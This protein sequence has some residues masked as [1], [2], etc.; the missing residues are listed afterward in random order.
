MIAHGCDALHPFVDGE[1]APE[2]ADAY[3]DH[4]VSCGECQERLPVVMA[5]VGMLEAIAE[6]KVEA[7]RLAEVVPF[8][9]RRTRLAVL[10]TVGLVAAAGFA[11]WFGLRGVSRP[12]ESIAMGRT[13]PSV[14]R[15]AYPGAATY[16][17]YDPDRGAESVDRIPFTTLA[18]ME[19]R[20]DWHG[21][22]VAAAL[23]GDREQAA[24]Y[25]A[26]ATA[27]PDVVVDRAALALMGRDDAALAEALAALEQVLAAHPD[28][29]A[30]AWN[31]AHILAR[32]G[33]SRIAAE[34]FERIAQRGEPQ[35][36]AEAT[37]TAASLRTTTA[38]DA[39]GWQADWDA[40]RELI[41]NGTLPA[42]RRATA[43]PGI[44]RLMFYD[45]VRTAPSADRVRA[46]LPLARELDAA[47]GGGEVLAGLIRRV[48]AARFD[49][50]GPL[51]ARYRTFVVDDVYPDAAAAARYLDEL[52]AAGPDAADLLLGALYRFGVAAANLDEYRRL[53]AGDP[54]FVALAAHEQARAALARGDRADAASVLIAAIRDAR[55]A[56]VHYRTE[57]L[58]TELAELYIALDRL[59]DAAEFARAAF[60]RARVGGEAAHATAALPLLARVALHRYQHALA[61]AYV[62][63]DLATRPD[64]CP[65]QQHTHLMLAQIALHAGDRKRARAELDLAP[66]CGK[67]PVL[68]RLVFEV[69]LARHAASDKTP[70]IRTALAELRAAAPLDP[71]D[72]A[73]LDAVEGS[74][75]IERDRAAG[76]TLLRKAIERAEQLGERARRA[77]GWAF[78]LLA[79]AA[80]RDGDNGRVL[81]LVA[82][83]K[84]LAVPE[85]CA[86]GVVIDDERLAIAARGAD[87][88]VLGHFDPAWPY[89]NK[90]PLGTKI[91]PD[92]VIAALAGCN[93]VD[94]LARP[95]V[96]GTPR[97][98]P[99]SIAWSYRLAPGESHAEQ[100]P[101]LRVRV[102]GVTTP[103]ALALPPL[104]PV[105]PADDNVVDLSGPSATPARLLAA[106]PDAT[107]IELHAH[108]VH[109]RMR[110]DASY[111]VLSPDPDGDYALTP[112]RLAGVKLRGAPLV[113]LAACGGARG[114][115]YLHEPDSLPAAFVRAGARAVL[116]T[117]DDVPDEEATRF[118][119]AVRNRVR[120]GTSLAAAL[121]DE[122]LEWLRRD[123]AS[124]TRDVLLYR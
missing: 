42:P 18:A 67:P 96:E 17:P 55:T 106:I 97:L 62:A 124:W 123:P 79:V 49:R 1:L 119:T 93:A 44:Y 114:E 14:A 100:V 13:R 61:A 29:A 71:N 28:H 103:G 53:A 111:V 78:A 92:D 85:R 115:P 3:R 50:R 32:L 51:V 66:A 68:A 87:G 84:R 34:A 107:E 38:A 58:E 21:I 118:F 113:T 122:R 70:E 110:S 120:A 10:I 33:L 57:L 12:A 46:L 26:R 8:R 45:A 64:E 77:R 102:S 47:A 63:E 105:S 39:T 7:A 23:A 82:E 37:R 6:P 94:V 15:F 56:R 22:G 116:A 52:R 109:D 112:A 91:V 24:R 69:A 117:Y 4:L 81:E 9:P 54:W 76:T 108:G 5:T 83:E 73:L 30:A 36:A 60:E 16:R 31:R 2:A 90:A 80:S 72:A 75:V 41:A 121:R 59:P 40:G 99:D 65:V 35:W 27:T 89:P 101:A 48:A 104:A 98:L 19:K 74:L 88:R 11:L 95:P 43:R 25:L 86:I 20:G